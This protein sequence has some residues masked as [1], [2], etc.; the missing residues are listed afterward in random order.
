MYDENTTPP[1]PPPGANGLIHRLQ[2]KFMKCEAESGAAGNR[3]RRTGA[4]EGAGR[5]QGAEGCLEAADS[6]RKAAEDATGKPVMRLKPI[7]ATICIFC[8]QKG[9]AALARFCLPFGAVQK[10]PHRK[11]LQEGG[12]AR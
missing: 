1:P 9:D 5:G 12:F 8:L 4:R 10:K 6:R 7:Q 11:P 2:I 3:A